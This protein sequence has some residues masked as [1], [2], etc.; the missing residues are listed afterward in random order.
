MGENNI[1][2]LNSDFI[3]LVVTQR[4]RE[5][6]EREKRQPKNP[7]QK[8]EGRRQPAKMD[9]DWVIISISSLSIALSLILI[10]Q[11]LYPLFLNLPP[12]EEDRDETKKDTNTSISMNN[13]NIRSPS[14]FY[15]SLGCRESEYYRFSSSEDRLTPSPG[16]PEDLSQQQNISNMPAM[17]A[18]LSPITLIIVALAFSDFMCSAKTL[19]AQAFNYFDFDVLAG[20]WVC[21]IEGF[22]GQLTAFTSATYAFVI[23]LILHSA[24]YNTEKSVFLNK[25]AAAKG[26]F[27]ILHLATWTLGLS[28]SFYPTYMN[29]MEPLSDIGCWI[30]EKKEGTYLNY[31][32][33]TFYGPLVLYVIFVCYL[34]F[35]LICRPKSSDDYGDDN[36]AAETTI[37]TSLLDDTIDEARKSEAKTQRRKGRTFILLRMKIFVN[38]FLLRWCLFLL[39]ALLYD[40]LG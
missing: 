8:E 30:K 29:Q 10:C 13:S 20:S 28:L 17:K 24:V 14:T 19:S 5:A 12:E 34:S 3:I 39:T 16:L 22:V 1:L 37:E 25:G 38:L 33:L 2:P 21:N 4:K 32:R 11:L 36:D 35:L 31:Y 23:G 27:K 7:N 6:R 18:T 15:S 40:S 26:A 9:V